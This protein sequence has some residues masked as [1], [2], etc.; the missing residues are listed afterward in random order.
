MDAGAKTTGNIGLWKTALI[1][2]GFPL[3]YMMFGTSDVAYA[4]F[5]QGDRNAY[6]L[7]WGG[8]VALHWASV[9]AVG[10][11]L[12]TSGHSFRDIGLKRSRTELIVLFALFATIAFAVFFGVESTIG[13]A[14]LS[15]AQ[16]RNLPGLV[17]ITTQERVFFI[18]LVFS[19]GFCEEAVYR[20]FAITG[21]S[22]AGIN[23][24]LGLIIAAVL[25][26]GIHGVNA[27]TN[28]F[29]FLFG[30]G[31]VFGILFLTT[32]SLLPPILLHWAINLS[33][34]LA[35]LPAVE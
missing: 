28:R 21:L 3:A 35:V 11:A 4:L 26:V 10:L 17:P 20:G 25:F 31:V 24:W 27:Y 18:L 7:F 8:I 19:T 33:A 29:L 34:M 30:G 6:F 1:I 13:P 16:T 23:R 12:F 5:V 22:D 32:R 2:I 14:G 15:E 9:G